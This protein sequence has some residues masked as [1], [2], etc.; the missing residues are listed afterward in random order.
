MRALS[1]T[2]GTVLV[3][4]IS[5]VGC[6]RSESGPPSSSPSTTA[7]S[8][9]TAANVYEQ[10]RADGVQTTLDGLGA[11][12]VAGDTARIDQLVDPAATPA[13]R[14]RIDTAAANLSRQ[15]VISDPP[16]AAQ[17]RGE[18]LQL[19]MFRYQ[20][21][22][23]E[24]AETLVPGE[25][26][27]TLDAAGSSDS[28]V[29][30]VE[31]HYALGGSALPGIDE[32]E[33]VV[34]TQF[35]M[36]RYG[37]DW[38]VVGDSAAIGGAPAPA[39]LVD[40][41]GLAADDVRTAG[42]ESVI[43]SYPGTADTVEDLR[44]LLPDA[45][46][47]VSAFWG[48]DWPRRAVVVATARPAEFRALADS[49]AT[50]VT[51]AA[52]A[53]VF[54]RIDSDTHTATGQRIVLTPSAGDLPAPALAVVL[55]HELTHV[56]ARAQTSPSAPLWITEGVAEYVGRKGTY[57]RFDDAAPNLADDV[58]AGR[59][60]V[61]LPADRDLA[62]DSDDALV[63]YQA[64]WSVAAYVAERYGDA[65]LRKLYVAVAGTDDPKRRDV[66]IQQAL[67]VSSAQLVADWRSWLTKQ[68]R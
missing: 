42:G 23:T 17:P 12:I 57:T 3:V 38:K 54:A 41:D 22:P 68:V 60:P 66:G 34:P 7:T 18:R 8:T 33:V 32:P 15:G 37:D 59:L 39:T 65:G 9:T 36:A 44:G 43:A 55:R 50:D 31:L 5:A 61:A 47:H 48:D 45:V 35:V 20:L 26:Q 21:A 16:P 24:E 49:S 1:A 52:A 40:L 4:T 64:A 14:A 19:K 46:E 6:A 10:Q 67:G 11:A 28:W 63:A 53:T 25:L 56:A 30:P 62:V 58:R 29:A 27:R 2:L 13:F 51:G